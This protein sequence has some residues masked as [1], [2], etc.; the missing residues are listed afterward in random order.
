MPYRG[1]SAT[2]SLAA[3]ATC[4]RQPLSEILQ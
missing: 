3:A 1:P 4:A 2:I